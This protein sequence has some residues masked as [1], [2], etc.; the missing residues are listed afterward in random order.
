MALAASIK[1]KALE[2]GFD[3]V[4]ITT[5]E[6]LDP[7]QIEK[8]S[9]WLSAGSAG[10]MH[11]MYKN[12]E[13]RTNPAELLPNA[14]SVICT[15]LNYRPGPAKEARTEQATCTA[16]IAN[17]ALYEDYHPFIKNLLR[18]LVEF[19]SDSAGGDWR[20]KICVDS[21]PLAERGLAQRA[22]LGFIGKNHMLINPQLG[23]QILLGEIITD[24]ELMPDEPLPEGCVDCEKCIRACPGGA[25]GSDGSFDAGKCISYLTI[26]HHGQIPNG[27]AEKIGSH[28]FGCD[29]CV[30]ICPYETSF[31]GRACRNKQFRIFPDRG[32]IDPAQISDWDSAEFD[33]YF[34][35]SPVER[36]GLERLKRNARI[37][38]KNEKTQQ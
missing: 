29:E 9:A 17:F 14:R 38:L 5:A 32:Q 35:G 31:S 1:Q 15:G 7:K 22:G 8:L 37:C 2:L 6:P 12:F 19:I 33:K 24:L 16:R 18:Q 36:L 34:A 4:G 20:F 23:S 26:E 30:L 21:V 13:K 28:L 25:I 3:L 11:Y 27:L 10:Q